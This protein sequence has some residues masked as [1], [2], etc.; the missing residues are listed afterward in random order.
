MVYCP[1][2]ALKSR[3]SLAR[4][5][6]TKVTRYAIQLARTLVAMPD[7]FQNVKFF[8]CVGPCADVAL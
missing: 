7:C 8:T 1:P 4:P 6:S 5:V 3:A 2:A